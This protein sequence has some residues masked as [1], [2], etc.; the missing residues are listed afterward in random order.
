[1]SEEADAKDGGYANADDVCEGDS[2]PKSLEVDS[3]GKPQMTSTSRESGVLET[4]AGVAGN[5]LEWY[6]FAVFGFL[7]NTIGDVFFPAQD[8]YAALIETFAVFGGAFLMRPLGGL[9]MGYIG[10]TYGRKKALEVSIFLMAV[11]TFV[12]GCLPS[13][14]AV[15]WLSPILLTITRL[16]QGLSVGGQLMSSLVFTLEGHPHSRWGLY[17][18][19]VMAAANIGTLLG[20]LIGTALQA[21]LT[22]EQLH[23]WGWRLP[24]LSGV[25]VSLSGFYLRYCVE[26][27]PPSPSEDASQETVKVN[28]LV[29]AFSPKNRWH[30]L[31]SCL[32]PTL[33][34]GGFY[35]AFVW[36]AVFM[37]DIVEPAVP[38]AFSVNAAALFFSVCC[39][40]PFAGM[41]SDKIGRRK[42]MVTG[43]VVIIL[44]GPLALQAIATGNPYYAFSAQCVLG[45]CL[46]SWCAPMMAW[47]VESFP[48]ESRLT[49]V[50]IGYNIA[51]ALVGGTAPAF[52]T[53]VASG[54]SPQNVGFIFSALALLALSGLIVAPKRKIRGGGTLTQE[55]TTGEQE[56]A[57]QG[58]LA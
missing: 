57:P 23:V 50:A 7:S 55:L 26:D 3:G 51:Q 32:V 43:S 39:F 5:V 22:Y 9:M 52:A 33:W 17:G 8:G 18:S 58:T 44:T 27:D 13:Y 6:D 14:E 37:D 56:S 10:D 35:L 19:F 47:L 20:G 11:P 54:G 12:M 16:V 24:F 4:I 48:P 31:A 30:L 45:V 53:Y 34:S 28:P 46:S 40:F 42:V 25:L 36:M 38:Y 49:A 1:M 21:T 2:A 15:G 41:L 29:D